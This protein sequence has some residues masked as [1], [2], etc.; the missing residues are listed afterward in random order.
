MRKNMVKKT[1][2]L[3][4]KVVKYLE[5]K[6]I[7]HEILEHRTVYTAMDAAATMRRKLGEIAKSLFVKANKDYYVVVLSAD[8]NVDF[9][10]L[11]KVIGRETGQKAVT[12]KIPGE[13]IM[14]N[15]LKVRA[16]TMSAFGGLHKLPVIADKGL[17]R[18]KKAVFSAGSFNHSAEMLVRDFVALENAVLGDFGKKKNIKIPKKAMAKPKAK[19]KSTAAQK[20]AKKE[21]KSK[22]SKK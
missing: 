19:K 21:V 16:G 3:P 17:A 14:E 1:T 2:K 5:A 4:S 22:R 9:K 11:G 7:D 20:T 18:A 10:R 15:V 12:V 13:K 6:G 8:R